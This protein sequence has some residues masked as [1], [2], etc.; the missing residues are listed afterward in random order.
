MK[1]K[2][3]AIR[4]T[5]RLN[6]IAKRKELNMTQTELATKVGLKKN[7]IASWE[8]GL[9]SPD[10]DTIA[11]LLKLFNMD[12]YEFTGIEREQSSPMP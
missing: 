9:S 3:T 4:E 7:S 8:Q 10:I 12:F 1:N 5:I 6:I 2:D 11:I